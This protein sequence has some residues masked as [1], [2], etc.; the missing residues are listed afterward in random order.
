MCNGEEEKG[1]SERKRMGYKVLKVR[2][3]VTL[4]MVALVSLRWVVVL[5]HLSMLPWGA[6]H[7]RDNTSAH[8]LGQNHTSAAAPRRLHTDRVMAFRY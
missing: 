8:P 3:V 5:L 2:G 4:A 7:R 1:K 6:Q